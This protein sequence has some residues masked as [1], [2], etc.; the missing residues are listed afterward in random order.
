[1]EVE[2]LSKDSVIKLILKWK[3]CDVSQALLSTPWGALLCIYFVWAN[4]KLQDI[5][6]M[7]KVESNR[8][9]RPLLTVWSSS[10]TTN[11]NGLRDNGIIFIPLDRTAAAGTILSCCGVEKVENNG[12]ERYSSSFNQFQ[13]LKFASWWHAGSSSKSLEVV[14]VFSILPNYS[15]SLCI[16]LTQFLF[17]KI[18]SRYYIQME[19]LILWI[20][21]CQSSTR[22]ETEV[23]VL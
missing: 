7:T 13:Q 6:K 15:R 22:V 1:M 18:T 23:G 5:I 16:L 11:S 17:Y 14:R 9:K 19:D 8:L 20:S 10:Y 2:L 21:F 3:P 12:N 4:W